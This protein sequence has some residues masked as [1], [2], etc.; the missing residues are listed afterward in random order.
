MEL[1]LKLGL[2]DARALPMLLDALPTPTAVVEQTNH[3]FVDDGG[4]LAARR[5]ML[6][7]RENRRLDVESSV[8]IVLTLKRR[9]NAAAGY[10]VAEEVECDLATDGWRAV[11]DGERDLSTLSAPPLAD[12]AID[13]PLRCH[14]VMRNTRHVIELGGY[15]LEV[16][17]TELP[18]DRVDAE[19]EVETDDPDGARQLVQARADRA[20]VQLFDQTLGK[21]ARFVAA[22]AP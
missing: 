12:L 17:R 13:T 3:Y 4:I 2:V 14:G 1:E 19:I 6:R 8:S 10:F 7:V 9:L 15:V 5:T 18:G 20:G 11:R 16:D 22:L 21:Y